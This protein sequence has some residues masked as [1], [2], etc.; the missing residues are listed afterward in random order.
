VIVSRRPKRT[1]AWQ[2]AADGYSLLRTELLHLMGNGREEAIPPG[3][4]GS[5]CAER[6]ILR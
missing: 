2:L 3:A 4:D 1:I 5:S 6:V